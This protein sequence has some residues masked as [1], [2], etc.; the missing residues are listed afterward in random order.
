MEGGPLR[1]KDLF[2]C[3]EMEAAVRKMKHV[4][5]DEGGHGCG[6]VLLYLP[7]TKV[8]T[9]GEG[10]LRRQDVSVLHTLI[11]ARWLLPR[12][13]CRWQRRT[14]IRKKT[15]SLLPA[16]RRHLRLR[17]RQELVG[18]FRRL[19]IAIGTRRRKRSK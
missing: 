2:A 14:A 10:V 18:A 9:K 15:H 3:R 8:D 19:A 16:K 11:C 13:S 7:A 1:T 5:I 12:D 17:P 4:Q 6:V